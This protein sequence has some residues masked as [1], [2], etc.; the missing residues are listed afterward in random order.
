MMTVPQS[1]LPNNRFTFNSSDY[2]YYQVNLDYI[3]KTYEIY[4]VISLNRVGTST[5]PI[6]WFEYVNPP[7]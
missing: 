5:S 7:A 1:T 4:D 3:S 2:F 6:N